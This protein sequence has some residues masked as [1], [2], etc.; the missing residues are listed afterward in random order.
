MSHF[1]GRSPLCVL[2]MAKAPVPG[3]VKTRLCPPFTHE[4]A[5]AI[6]EAC[7]ADTLAAVAGCHAERKI[8]ALDGS[9]GPWLPPG[10]EVIGQRGGRFDQRLA[11]AWADIATDTSASCAVSVV[12]SASGSTGAW[13]IQIGM[14]T[15]QVTSDLLDDQLA[16]LTEQRRRSGRRRPAALLG[17]ASDGG[18]WLIGLPGTDPHLVFPGVPMS[19]SHTGIA[20]ARRLRSLGLRIVAGPELVD[21]DD[22]ESLCCVAADIPASRTAAAVRS[23]AVRS[24]SASALAVGRV[25]AV[26]DPPFP[27]D[28]P[29]RLIGA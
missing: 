6:A 9:A 10:I 15:P 29:G 2:V 27:T 21:I 20:Q 1:S 3:R 14:D 17:A 26:L 18:W 8:I 11:N 7:L 13:G 5:A 23:A 24:A 12:G 16:A 22:A 25:R 4:D 28:R 19:T